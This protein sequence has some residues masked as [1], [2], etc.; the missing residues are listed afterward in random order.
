MHEK[1]WPFDFLENLAPNDILLL[2]FAI[3]FVCLLLSVLSI[4]IQYRKKA[5]LD[6]FMIFYIISLVLFV[7][8]ATAMGIVAFINSLCFL[9]E[10]HPYKNLPIESIQP[11]MLYVLIGIMLLIFA[12]FFGVYTAVKSFLLKKRTNVNT[13]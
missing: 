13:N 2:S 8:L 1:L 11:Y 4:L 7:S 3:C 12:G 6:K 9:R 5:D 10:G